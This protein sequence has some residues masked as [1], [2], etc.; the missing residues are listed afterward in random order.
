MRMKTALSWRGFFA[1]YVYCCIKGVSGR[2]LSYE[3]FCSGF[4]IYFSVPNND[5][6]A[7]TG[8]GIVH[9]QMFG[10]AA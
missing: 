8:L 2:R 1:G 7:R 6:P 9:E 5:A 4:L 10:W 3:V